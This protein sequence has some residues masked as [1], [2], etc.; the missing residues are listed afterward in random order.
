MEEG[1]WALV[2]T[3]GFVNE[4]TSSSFEALGNDPSG[5]DEW[6]K[7]IKEFHPCWVEASKDVEGEVFMSCFCGNVANGAEEGGKGGIHDD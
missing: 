6:C 4:D 1:D 3:V 2:G 5:E 7:L